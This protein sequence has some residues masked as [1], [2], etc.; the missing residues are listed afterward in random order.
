MQKAYEDWYANNNQ[1]EG[2]PSPEELLQGASGVLGQTI[3]GPIGGAI[4]AR[5]FS[6]EGAVTGKDAFASIL[7]FGT[8]GSLDF[9]TDQ[10]FNPATGAVVDA[11]SKHAGPRPE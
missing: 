4:G 8:K 7:P 10:F 6:P 11:G 3:G 1:P 9:G 5:L 2:F